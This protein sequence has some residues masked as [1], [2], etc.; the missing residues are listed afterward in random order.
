MVECFEHLTS[1]HINLGVTNED[2]V[3]LHR[4]IFCDEG[5]LGWLLRVP[6][7]FWIYSDRDGRQNLEAFFFVEA[8]VEAF[9]EIIPEI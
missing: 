6:F 4:F 7:L 9:R 1:T 2:H 3:A 5:W 8:E